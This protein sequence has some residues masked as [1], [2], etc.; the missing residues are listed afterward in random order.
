MIFFALLSLAFSGWM[1]WT[2]FGSL[3]EAKPSGWRDYLSTVW[4]ASGSGA[5]AVVAVSL[6]LRLTS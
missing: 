6:L 3:S 1:G 2:L 4:I 5:G